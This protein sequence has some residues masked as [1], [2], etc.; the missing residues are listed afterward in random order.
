MATFSQ[1]FA[2]Q[3][4]RQKLDKRARNSFR[5][6]SCRFQRFSKRVRRAIEKQ[7]ESSEATFD[8][9]RKGKK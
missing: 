4:S 1:L 7:Q 6:V 3:A 8:F 2:Q 5:Y 9:E